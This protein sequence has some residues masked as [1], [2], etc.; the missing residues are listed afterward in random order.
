MNFGF[1][2]SLIVMIFA[3][4]SVFIEIPIVSNYAFWFA[5]GAYIMLAG[6]CFERSE[7]AGSSRSRSAWQRALHSLN[8]SAESDPGAGLAVT[9]KGRESP[10]QLSSRPRPKSG[11]GGR[12]DSSYPDRS[13]PSTYGDDQRRPTPP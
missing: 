12:G 2:A 6:T 4:L 13:Y 11:A 7:H 10:E 5:V 8:L 9:P 1:V 3:V